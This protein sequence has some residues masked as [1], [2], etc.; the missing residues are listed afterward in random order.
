MSSISSLLATAVAAIMP[1]AG[2][3]GPVDAQ[4]QLSQPDPAE[5]PLRPR[6]PKLA[7][8]TLRTSS[9]ALTLRRAVS[10]VTR[11]TS[12]TVTQRVPKRSIQGSTV[13]TCRAVSWPCS[14]SWP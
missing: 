3:T 9:P 10:P 2:S 7:S 12:S 5:R 11:K 13:A 6:L 4:E 8:R 1:F 14:V